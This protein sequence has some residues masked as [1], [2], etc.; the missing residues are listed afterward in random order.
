[1]SQHTHR[2]N[3]LSAEPT[4]RWHFWTQIR[5]SPAILLRRTLSTPQ[6]G[7]QREIESEP[8]MRKLRFTNISMAIIIAIIILV[9][10]SVV[11]AASVD[12]NKDVCNNVPA[13]GS[14]PSFCKD[15]IGDSSDPNQNPIYGPNGIVTKV[16]N[17]LSMMVG[18]AAVLF[19]M[20]AGF[21]FIISGHSSEEI[22]KQ[23]EYIIYALIALVIIAVA[24]LMVRYVLLQID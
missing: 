3:R 23:R 9:V 16:V 12:I 2:A 14:P 6:S 7:S 21:R 22:N 15:Q 10:P 20:V 8:Q 4:T 13:G 18:V 1:M 11:S 17:I 5:F 19:I 24:Q